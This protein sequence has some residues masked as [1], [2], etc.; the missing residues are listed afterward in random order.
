MENAKGLY[1]EIGNGAWCWDTL[2]PR[3]GR[4]RAFNGAVFCPVCRG[5]WCRVA[6]RRNARKLVWQTTKL[7]LSA[8][9]IVFY[10][11]FLAA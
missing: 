7:L 10:L 1:Q 9:L 8:A 5:D 11:N 3:S 2:P 6:T 4:D